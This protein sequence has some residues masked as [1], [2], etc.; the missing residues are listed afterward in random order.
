VVTL[1]S[2]EMTTREI[3]T[4]LRALPDGSSVTIT[5]PQGRH[6]LAVGLTNRIDITVEGSAGHYLGGLCDG[7]SIR[8]E[9]FVGWAAGENLMSGLVRVAG[10]A[11]ERV[12]ASAHGGHVIVGGDASS[13]AAISLKGGTV[14]VAGDVGHMSA[15]MAQ[16]GILLVGGD[17][18]EALGDSLY[19][20]IIYVGGKI[21]SLG[22]DAITA[23]LTDGDVATL[24]DLITKAGFTHLDPEN[25]TKVVS[26]KELYNFDAL[27]AH[28]Y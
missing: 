10:N 5:D 26:A 13:R 7:P 3:N 25:M 20:A 8:A 18:G 23:D 17:A 11:S 9:G 6:N 24:D 22:S 1:I 15:F 21:R 19:E 28:K 14:L 4:E 2:S 27:K 12:A 16:A